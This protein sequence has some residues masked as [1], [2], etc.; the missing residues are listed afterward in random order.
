MKTKSFLRLLTLTLVAAS[1]LFTTSCSDDD[2]D[3]PTETLLEIIQGNANYSEFLEFYD[4]NAANLPALEGQTIFVP[5]N[6]AFDNLRATLGVED[7]TTVN[8]SVITA[9]LAFHFVTGTVLE[10]DLGTSQS[11]AQGEA[12]AFNDDGTIFTGGSNTAVTFGITDQEA[13]NGVIHEVNTILI[14]PT[15]FGAIAT[16]LGKVSQA[17]FLGADFTALV[18]GIAV[19]DAFATE[20]GLSTITEILRGDGPFTL[21]APTNATF[22]QAGITADSFDGQTWYGILAN[23]VVAGTVAPADLTA[24]AT[25]Q[26][27]A[28]ATLTVVVADPTNGLGIYFLS[29]GDATPDAE[30]ALPNAFEGSNGVLHVIAGVLVP[31]TP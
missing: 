17:I 25:F 29:N 22:E 23:H 16:D 28:N 15:I 3:K 7:L 20:A 18:S 2:D 27:L 30:V 1:L 19:A 10:K 24:G 8:P 6:G 11:T 31:P 21:F 5:N 13:T 14:P 26:T 9:V 4:A 12:I